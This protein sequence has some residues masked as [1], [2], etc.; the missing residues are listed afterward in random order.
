MPELHD[1]ATLLAWAWCARSSPTGP[2]VPELHVAA[3]YL[4]WAWCARSSPTG[5]GVPELH[6]AIPVA[7]VDM[8]GK[9][10]SAGTGPNPGGGMGGVM[11]AVQGK[12]G[13]PKADDH[14][15][16]FH[17][18]VWPKVGNARGG[19]EPTADGDMIG[20]TAAPAET[21]HT[22]KLWLVAGASPEATGAG[23]AVIA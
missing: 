8:V 1:P 11:G 4:A 7:P 16:G 2:G 6:V 9:G 15:K 10:G 13:A 22:S 23:E 19:R 3:T 17:P 20:G 12:P 5:P 14:Q 21:P 18:G